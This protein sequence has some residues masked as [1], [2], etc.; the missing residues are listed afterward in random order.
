MPPIACLIARTIDAIL[1]PLTN[2]Y[3]MTLK[4]ARIQ[5]LKLIDL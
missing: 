2:L 5:A 4:P 1:T 3:F